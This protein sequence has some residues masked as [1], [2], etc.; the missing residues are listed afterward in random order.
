[1]NAVEVLE[2]T[3]WMGTYIPVIPVYG[4]EYD[5]DGT[6]FLEGVVRNAKDP[7]RAYNYWTSAQTEA[8]ALAP[9]APYIAA[10][11]QIEGYE[12]DWANANNKNLSTLIYKPTSIAGIPVAPPQRNAVEPAVQAI[13]QARMMAT[14]DIKA[15]TGIYDASLGAA[16]N[17]TS[18][19]A[20]QRRNNQALTSNFHFVDNLTRSQRHTGRI[21]VDLIPK[22]YDTPRIA[23]VVTDENEQKIVRVNDPTFVENGK[24]TLYALDAGKYDVTIDTGPSYQ[25]KREEAV[26]SMLEMT[27]SV[28]QIGA[29][30]ADLMVKNMD[31]PGAQEVAERIKKTLPPNLVDDP[32]NKQPLPPDVQA[33]MDQMSQMV[34]NLS[35]E[36]H[37]AMDEKEKKVLEIESNE[38]IAFKKLEVQVEIE[39]AKLGAKDSIELLNHEIAQINQRL[40]LLQ[41]QE[42][43]EDESPQQEAQESYSTQNTLG[44]NGAG[45]EMAEHYP[46]GG[47]SPGL[48]LGENP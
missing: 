42:P 26:A 43:V 29:V 19:V 35:E 31:W 25:T 44:A 1:M 23:R 45:S 17:E 40:Q 28:P 38:R 48:P 7:A 24:A 21:L 47:Q 32:K 46:T 13:T 27:R 22:I 16:S 6:R 8:I 3:D 9:R 30:A 18:G 20:I 33:K 5:I 34:S 15:T 41:I 12:D 36:L 10:E 37:K 11:G 14:D 2:M 39:M 4:T